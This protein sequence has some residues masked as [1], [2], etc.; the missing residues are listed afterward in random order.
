ML[1]HLNF[2][3]CSVDIYGWQV[4]QPLWHMLSHIVMNHV[5]RFSTKLADGIATIAKA[6]VMF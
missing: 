3:F 2:G 1:C 6:D 5:G 4:E